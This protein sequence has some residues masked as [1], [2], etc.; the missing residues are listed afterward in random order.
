MESKQ[1]SDKTTAPIPEEMIKHLPEKIRASY[2]RYITHN[3]MEAAD[4]VVL[5]IV[6]DHVPSRKVAQIPTDLTDSSTLVGDLGIDSVSIADAV[7]V[8]EDVFDV[9]IS[10]K[11]LIR[12]RTVG[13]L[14]TF[15]RSKHSKTA[16]S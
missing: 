3:D 9:S 15:I 2:Q 14:R 7:F 6:K 13:D 5:A 12:L 1:H 11:E 16:A 4:E 8:L 10:N